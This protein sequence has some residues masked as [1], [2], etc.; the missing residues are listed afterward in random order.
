MILAKADNS[1]ASMSV[2]SLTSPHVYDKPLPRGR[3]SRGVFE[4]NG[5][6]FPCPPSGISITERN[7]NFNFETLRTRESTKIRSGRG[8][9]DITVSAIFTGNTTGSVELFEG[10]EMPSDDLTAINETLMPIL[11]SLKKTPLCFLDNELLRTTLPI[12]P[13]EVIGAMCRSVAI[14]TVPSMPFAL[15]VEFQFTWFNH[16]PY[17]PRI[18]FRKDWYDDLKTVET[19]ESMYNSIE[20]GYQKAEGVVS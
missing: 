16:R 8:R 17:T 1:E 13:N 9:F 3:A 4:I 19:L 18:M 20:S 7:Q 5:I 2:A 10:L 12:V 14:S 15:S 6:R 11:Y